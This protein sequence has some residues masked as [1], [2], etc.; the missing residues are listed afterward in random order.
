MA[1]PI[2]T[3][4]LN[5]AGRTVFRRAGKFITESDF[6]KGTRRGAAGKFISRGQ[7]DKNSIIAQRLQQKFGPPLG[8]GNWVSRVRQSTER[9]TELSGGDDDMMSEFNSP[10]GI[11]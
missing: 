9:F 1:A 2:F 6:A 11:H 4:I 10:L 7:A 8:G 5:K 3:A